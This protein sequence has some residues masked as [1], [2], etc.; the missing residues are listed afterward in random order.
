MGLAHEKPPHH[1]RAEG[2]EGKAYLFQQ[3]DKV[4]VA[5]IKLSVT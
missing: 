1:Y 2:T 4:I 5:G 3:Q